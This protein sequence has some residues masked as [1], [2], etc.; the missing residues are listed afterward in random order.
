MEKN[1]KEQMYQ[2]ENN[3]ENNMFNTDKKYKK[4]IDYLKKEL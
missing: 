2:I 1:Y 4:N 3:Y